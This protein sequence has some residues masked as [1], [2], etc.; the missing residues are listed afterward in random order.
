MA[1]PL[2]TPSNNYSLSHAG[3]GGQAPFEYNVF[4]NTLIKQRKLILGEIGGLEM[5]VEGR[6][7]GS[8]NH[9]LK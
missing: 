2:M 3:F 7:R 8:I 1:A 9:V 5:K 4:Q 6:C